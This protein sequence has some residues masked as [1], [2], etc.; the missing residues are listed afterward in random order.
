[1][2]SPPGSIISAHDFFSQ[3]RDAFYIKKMAGVHGQEERALQENEVAPNIIDDCP[4]EEDQ[5]GADDIA[6]ATDQSL[7]VDEEVLEDDADSSS[8]GSSDEDAVHEQQVDTSVAT[9]QYF[10][11]RSTLRLFF[12]SYET[13]F[14]HVTCNTPTG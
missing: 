7:P 5:S 6:S 9:A 8:C 3:V 13:L 11:V 1:M 2:S 10:S 14:Y 4:Q 12:S